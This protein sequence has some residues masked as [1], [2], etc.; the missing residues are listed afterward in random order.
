MA[1]IYTDLYIII[2]IIIINS[3]YEDSVSLFVFCG[4]FDFRIQSF[5]EQHYV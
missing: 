2:I 4:K 3:F 5:R 1:L